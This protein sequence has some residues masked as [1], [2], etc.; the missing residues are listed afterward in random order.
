MIALA[1]GHAACVGR[2]YVTVDDVAEVAIA[3][4]SH[5]CLSDSVANRDS[6]VAAIRSVL[7]AVPVPRG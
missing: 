2:D 3:A 7:S 5:R 4:L 6:T 1:R